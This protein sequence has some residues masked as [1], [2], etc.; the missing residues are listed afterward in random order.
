MGCDRRLRQRVRCRHVQYIPTY[1]IVD[2]EV[3]ITCPAGRDACLDADCDVDL[4]TEA[5]VA[6][7]AYSDDCD[8]APA[9]DLSYVDG[10]RLR[11]W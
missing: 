8:D 4:S 3:A 11:L 9:L 1:D 6:T 5:N 7:V 2:P 10:P